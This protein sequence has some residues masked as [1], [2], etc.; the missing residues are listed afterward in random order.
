MGHFEAETLRVMIS[1]SSC[2]FP[3]AV[4]T[5]GT[6]VKIN[7]VSAWIL[8]RFQGA[9]PSPTPP[10]PLDT[11]TFTCST[12]RKE[13]PVML[14]CWGLAIS[15]CSMAEPTGPHLL[16]IIEYSLLTEEYYGLSF[17]KNLHCIQTSYIC[18]YASIPPYL[19]GSPR[20][21][22]TKKKKKCSGSQRTK[23]RL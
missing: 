21:W 4:V 23:V 8:E 16:C 15:Y 5:L 12:R 2:S 7:A 10:P 22:K 6:H 11:C 20:I 1:N 9:E 13:T 3:N 18:S 19:Q 14:S 17:S